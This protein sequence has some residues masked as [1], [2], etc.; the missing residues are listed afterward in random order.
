MPPPTERVASSGSA[1]SSA[2]PGSLW[3]LRKRGQKRSA[4]SSS[5]RPPST[6][7]LFSLPA[8]SLDS[9]GSLENMNSFLNGMN[10]IDSIKSVDSVQSS[11]FSVL[12]GIIK[13][14]SSGINIPS[15]LT[16][17]VT[18]DDYDYDAERLSGTRQ[19]IP[20]G[21]EY[22]SERGF[23]GDGR[24]AEVQATR[25]APTVSASTTLSTP[26][27]PYIMKNLYAQGKRLVPTP[28]TTSTT[29]KSARAT[30]PKLKSKRIASKKATVP[31][32]EPPSPRTA[33]KRIRRKEPVVRKYVAATDMDVLLGR[34]GGSNHHPGNIAYRRRILDL[35]PKYKALDRDEKTTMSEDV[36]KWLQEE[37]RGRFL[38]RESKA[39]PWYIVTNAT[40]RQKVSQ[41]LREDHT[42]EGRALK[43]SRTSYKVPSKKKKKRK[44][45][46]NQ[47]ALAAAI[48][49]S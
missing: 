35:Q 19:I 25:M 12:E 3:F 5:F 40:A 43:K 44:P 37:R 4:I 10:S 6:G 29:K 18:P 2:P 48:E 24:D 38:K 45:A 27:P 8:P 26:F 39:S 16:R 15:S 36:V 30:A 20:D 46:L 7:S 21:Y 33:L 32:V 1:S 41:A 42:L 28:T 22:D 11:G 23:S 17:K 49:A 14:S 9:L 34:G 47:A 13:S 31:K